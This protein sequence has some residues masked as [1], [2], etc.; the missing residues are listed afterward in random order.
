ML[1]Y[2]IHYI[3]SLCSFIVMCWIRFVGKKARKYRPM[4]FQEKNMIVL[5]NFKLNKRLKM[6][7]VEFNSHYQYT[8]KLN[9]KGS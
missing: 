4:P 1:Y 3:C 7:S 9:T 6:I 8:D 5:T 2:V